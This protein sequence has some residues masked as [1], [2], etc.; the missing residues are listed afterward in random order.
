MQFHT[1]G[2]ARAP[3]RRRRAL[4]AA[5]SILAGCRR[6]VE[7]RPPE[8]VDAVGA[9][10]VA[11]VYRLLR[12]E[13]GTHFY[14]TSTTELEDASRLGMLYLDAPFVS[15]DARHGEPVYRF[16]DVLRGTY[17]Y[18]ASP[19]ER[20]RVLLYGSHMR[21]E[22]VGFHMRARPSAD[23]EAVYR[24]RDPMRHCFL[25]SCDALEQARLIHRGWLDDGVAFH[26]C[27][28]QG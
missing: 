21:F 24:L 10:A 13:N 26:A 18:T 28:Q 1:E 3:M 14:T 2:G 15:C 4:I 22:G 20:D 25:Y 17:F 23:T 12:P 8:F 27:R 19:V 7:G 5:A 16:A 11:P 9:K 6:T